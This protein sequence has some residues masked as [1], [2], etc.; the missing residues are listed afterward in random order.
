MNKKPPEL[1]LID[2]T[3]PRREKP[4]LLPSSVKR[5][6]PKAYWADNPEAWNKDKFIEETSSFLYE[7]YGIG[8][9]QDQHLLAILAD[10]IETYVNANRS[11]K[12]N[13]LVISYNNGQTPG[14]NPMISIRNK[15]TTYIIQLMNELG[16]TPRS[17][18]TAGKVEDNS[19]IGKL[20]RGP[21][22]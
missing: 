14:P 2:G 7:V 4:T 1:H 21:A 18:L 19:A 8:S 3:T 22:F 15:A 13:T 6:V 9:D 12:S 16:L 10:H 17:R 5:R 11:I 20:M